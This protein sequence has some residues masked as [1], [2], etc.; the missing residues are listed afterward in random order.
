MTYPIPDPARSD[1]KPAPST[2]PK[3]SGQKTTAV[4]PEERFFGRRAD[5]VEGARREDDD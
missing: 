5:P 4:E 1:N 3:P 2:A